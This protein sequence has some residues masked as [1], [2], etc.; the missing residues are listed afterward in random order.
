M[1]RL[2]GQ[3]ADPEM[4]RALE[5]ESDLRGRPA[6][7]S[8][9]PDPKNRSDQ[10]RQDYYWN[11]DLPRISNKVDH[12]VASRD[13]V[14]TVRCFYPKKE[15]DLPA[16]VFV[17]GGGWMSGSLVS[18]ERL[19]RKVA[20]ESNSVV[21]GVDYALAPE[22]PYPKAL[23]QIQH[24]IEWI[25]QN[26]PELSIRSS[27]MALFGASAGANL[28]LATAMRL[29]DLGDGGCVSAL[30]LYIGLYSR[31]FGSDSFSSFDNTALGPSKARIEALLDLYDPTSRRDVEPYVLPLEAD[32]FGGLPPM[33]ICAGGMDTL[34]DD[35]VELSRR[36]LRAGGE[37]ELRIADG[38]GHSFMKCHRQI[39]K[40]SHVIDQ[41]CR[42][43]RSKL[44]SETTD[45]ETSAESSALSRV[46][47]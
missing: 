30:A 41:G 12:S 27:R 25:R 2:N 24:V 37:A 44:L 4:I 33:F 15:R 34:R 26:G 46:V 42:F 28:A 22:H 36:V 38:L 16:T 45:F 23:R 1:A 9:L 17:F 35:S 7:K 8:D 40:A 43:L 10:E 29:R 6:D 32:D 47:D 31:N 11:L 3:G 14:I 13:G 18:N 20:I 5:K 21:V 19:M 39:T